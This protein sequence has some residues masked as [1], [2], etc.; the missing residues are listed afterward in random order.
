MDWA[1][2][3]RKAWEKWACPNIGSTGEPLKAA[4]LLNYEPT[5]PSRLLSTMK[6]EQEGMKAN[7]M[8]MNQIVDFVKRNN[9]QIEQ[10]GMKANPMEINQIVDFVKRNNLQFDTFIIGANQYMV[11]SIHNNWFST[12]CINTKNPAGEGAI[13]K[14]TAAFL[15][16][17]L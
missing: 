4:L 10:E 15:L 11:T 2:V 9:L 14:Q 8:E 1:F 7:P 12:R 17:A 16:I 6:I 3:V 5:G 13:V